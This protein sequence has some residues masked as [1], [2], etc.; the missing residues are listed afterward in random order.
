LHQERSFFGIHRVVLQPTG[1][2]VVLNH[3]TTVHG[4][5]ALR[6]NASEALSALSFQPTTYYCRSGPLGDIVR[7]LE[8]EGRLDSVG[9]IGLGAGTLAAYASPGMTM[10]FFEIDPTVCR[11]AADPRY[12][13]Y[14]ADAA[15]KKSIT[16]FGYVG[17]GRLRLA[18]QP[19]G[20]YD[21][22]VV[23]AFASDSI[24]MHLITREAVATYADRLKP[25]GL[26]AFNI[27][28]RYFNLAPPLAAIAASLKLSAAVRHDL[29]IP[30]NEV[31][32]GKH[33][34]IWVA[35][36]TQPRIE[37]LRRARPDWHPI[38]LP[39]NHGVWTDD[40]GN[41]LGAFNGW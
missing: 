30:E 21:L 2:W 38:P 29:V 5:Q 16:L 34:S 35:V 1:N 32:M 37:T 33:G 28:N 36:G 18:E 41:L 17:D 14:L 3:G 24:P 15:A 10:H 40:Y 20:S 12:F 11:I 22:I 27:S 19:A 23:D 13:T 31:A 8:S 39:D 26:I 9:V 6:H 4:V 25:G 7:V